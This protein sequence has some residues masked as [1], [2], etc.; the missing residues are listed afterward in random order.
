[1]EQ[2]GSSIRPIRFT[3]V[4]LIV[5][6]LAALALALASPPA[7]TA[8]T[9]CWRQI[10]NDWLD[11]QRIDDRYAVHCYQEAI[12]HVPEDLRVYSNI[13]QDIRA[14]RQRVIREA[15]GSPRTLQSNNPPSQNGT[16]GTQP[17]RNPPVEEPTT[18]EQPPKGLFNEAFDKVGPTNAD[19]IPLPLLI[20]GG[21]ALLLI[22][23]GAAGLVSRHLRARRLPAP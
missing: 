15:S 16:N 3:A 21:L 11:N 18:V 4:S 5:A 17:N 1:L 9:P 12:D 2:V 20:L 8:A 7:A 23:A 19:S 6:A 13:E 14:A 22:A 10:L